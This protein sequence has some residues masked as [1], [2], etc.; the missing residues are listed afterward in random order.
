[1][2]LFN[3]VK[4]VALACM[5]GIINIQARG[6]KVC[7]E[8]ESAENIEKPMITLSNKIKNV[9]GAVISIPEKAG[10]PPELCKGSAQYCLELPGKGYYTLW[11][12]VWW[13]GECSN[14][15]TVRI[16][17]NPPILFGEDATYKAWHWVK[18]PVSRTSPKIQLNAGDHSLKIEN[19][20]DGIMIDQIILSADKR[21]V[22]VDIEETGTFR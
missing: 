5:L 13:N 18:Y 19:R 21:F 8:A 22:P 16:N 10:N 7:F 6:I 2:K 15:F 9:S 17:E 20:E 12:R 4:L 14:S 3:P 11:C 1:M